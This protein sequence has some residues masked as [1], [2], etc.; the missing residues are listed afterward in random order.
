MLVDT[1]LGNRLSRAADMARRAEEQGYDAVWSAETGNDP[2]LPLAL[3][4]TATSH[5]ALGTSIA[6]A[7]GRNP[8]TLAQMGWD[9]NQLSGGRFLLGL[10]SQIKPHIV[11]RY[12]MPWSDPAAR[13]REMILAMQAIWR[14]WADGE[15][16]DFRGEYYTHTLMTPMFTPPD[17]DHGAPKVFLAGVG[18][19]MT[20]TAG[21]TADGF[22]AHPF[23]TAEFLR[24]VTVPKLAEGRAL[25]GRTDPV[26]IALPSFVVTG[27][28]DEETAA[29]RQAVKERV[30]FYGS[31]PAYRTVLEHHGWGELQPQLNAMSKQGQWKEMADLI[32]DDILD[33]FAV[34][35]PPDQ[36]AERLVARF[37]NNVDRLTLDT[38]NKADPEVINSI[39]ADLK[40]HA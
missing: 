27:K 32:S 6:V 15:P 23:T 26:T 4:A 28:D 37:G 20:R 22:F 9:L 11:K 39:V 38:S 5:T 13:M 3:A 16:L 10:G 30:A 12:S 40:A 31:T 2:F 17:R 1:I 19:L 14:T 25:A 24:E 36:V 33:A 35:A 21:E 18:P 8:M 34:V 29:V 7:F